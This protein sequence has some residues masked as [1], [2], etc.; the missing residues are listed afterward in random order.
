MLDALFIVALV[1]AAY[2]Y[3]VYP[4]ILYIFARWRRDPS[5]RASS[6]GQPTVTVVLAA[7][8]EAAVIWDRIRNLQ[9]GGYPADRLDVLVGSDGST[10]ETITLACAA[11]EWGPVP[12]Q[13]VA[14]PVRR[15]KAAVVHDLIMRARGEV[16]VMS[17]ANTEFAPDAIAQLARWFGDDRVGCVVGQ[18]DVLAGRN[19][20]EPERRY[21]RFETLLKRWENRLGAVL[22]ANGGIYA[23]RRAAYMPLRP[24]VITDDFVLPLLIRLQGYRLVFDREAGAREHAAPTVRHEF[25]RRTRIAAGNMQALSLTRA[26]LHPR[27]GWTA[28]AYWSH[29]VLRWLSPFFWTIAAVCA[30]AQLQRP[31]YAAI[32]TGLIGLLGISAVGWLLERMGRPVR[33]VVGAAY[34]AVALNVALAAGALRFLGGHGDG[35][36]ERTPRGGR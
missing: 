13:V 17:D 15:G 24:G 25:H 6:N 36:W 18:L 2:P 23:F 31:L 28:F 27:A 30:V 16:V 33:G 8:N 32:V 5:P 35:R 14:F 11:A 7:H 20:G 22:G 19:G 26:L 34:A 10:D 29:K 21:W 12:V 3:A 4:G 1:V 9:G